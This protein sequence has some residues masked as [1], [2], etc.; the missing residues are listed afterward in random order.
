MVVNAIAAGRR[1]ALA[2]DK[3]LRGDTSRVEVYDRKTMVTEERAA[4][5][6]EI[7]ETKPRTKVK[8]LPLPERRS[9]FAEIELGMSEEIARRE[10]KRCLRCD[11]EG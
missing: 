8:T 11:L 9:S 6:D 7:W 3:Y 1:S 10:A 2:I 4:E 5:L